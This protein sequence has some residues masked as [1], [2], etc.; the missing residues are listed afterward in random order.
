MFDAYGISFASY[1]P[2]KVKNAM[3][4]KLIIVCVLFGSGFAFRWANHAGRLYTLC[5]ET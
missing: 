2:F 1:Y 4:N 3:K 5:L